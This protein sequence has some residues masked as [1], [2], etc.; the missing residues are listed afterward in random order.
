VVFIGLIMLAGIVVN[1]AI[2]LVTRINQL[3]EEGWCARRIAEAGRLRLRPIVMTTLTTALGLLPLA[4][5]L[6]EGAEMRAPM[7][8][9]VIGGLLL[10]TALTLVV[11]PVV[12]SLLDRRRTEADNRAAAAV[13]SS[14]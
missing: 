14:P 9:T 1:N 2:V 4:L 11:I 10:S 7:A 13:P 3:R 6:G 12:Y 8:V 5:G